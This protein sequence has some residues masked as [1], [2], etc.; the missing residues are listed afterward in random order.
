M[1]SFAKRMTFLAIVA[2]AVRAF[3][4]RTRDFP[5]SV[6]TQVKQSRKA[7]VLTNPYVSAA[8]PYANIGATQTYRP[9]V[10]APA[11]SGASGQAYSYPAIP[12]TTSLNQYSSAANLYTPI[13][14]TS[15]TSTQPSTQLLGSYNNA[16]TSLTNVDA[17]TYANLQAR[18]AAN[19]LNEAPPTGIK[20]I[21]Q[22]FS[23]ANSALGSVGNGA[24]TLVGTASTWATKFAT[25]KGN[26]TQ[27]Q[28]ALTTGAYANS[29]D[30]ANKVNQVNTDYNNQLSSIHTQATASGATI[31]TSPAAS[32]YTSTYGSG[33]RKNI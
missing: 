15:L 27:Q 13:S 12:K 2:T 23:R 32:M 21:D 11:S 30:F 7:L 1:N 20:L 14:S 28:S 25:E 4:G 19:T 10:V 24:N 33:Y 8:N 3:S 5:L 16:G 31:P 22:I 26:L 6:P 9:V 18:V 29:V 17:S